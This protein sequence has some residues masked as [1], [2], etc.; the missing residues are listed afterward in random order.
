MFHIAPDRQSPARFADRLRIRRHRQQR[1]VTS[2]EQ[3]EVY[4]DL[5]TLL[6]AGD[7]TARDVALG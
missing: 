2:D 5:A 6:A 3:F 7:E 4:T 1:T